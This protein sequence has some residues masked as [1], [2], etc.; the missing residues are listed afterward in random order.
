MEG[1]ATSDKLLVK[2]YTENC[3]TSKTGL[4]ACYKTL[5]ESPFLTL[6]QS[7]L[8]ATTFDPLI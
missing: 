4:V 1:L 5:R 3:Q 6:C 8:R 2:V 7:T